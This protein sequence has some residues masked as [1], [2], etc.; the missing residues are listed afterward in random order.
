M[1]ELEICLLALTDDAEWRA[2]LLS[3][4]VCDSEEER[5]FH[6]N[7]AQLAFEGSHVTT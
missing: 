4:V 5:Q 3:T 2:L 7:A 6:R 1:R